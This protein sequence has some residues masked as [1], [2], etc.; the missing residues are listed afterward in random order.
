MY[1]KITKIYPLNIKNVRKLC[2]TLVVFT[3]LPALSVQTTRHCRT[4]A[5]L[6][7]IC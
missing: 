1:I 6:S 5:K 4:V 7:F 2:Q 3:L